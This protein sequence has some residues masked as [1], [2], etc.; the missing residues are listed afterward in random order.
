MTGA[1]LGGT[2]ARSTYEAVL[3][4]Q[5]G[6]CKSGDAVMYSQAI[7]EVNEFFATLH[8]SCRG[9]PDYQV[10]EHIRVDGNHGKHPEPRSCSCTTTLR[11]TTGNLAPKPRW[12]TMLL[13]GSD[14]RPDPIGDPLDLD[15]NT[16]A[17]A[18]SARRAAHHLHA[19]EH[20][21]CGRGATEDVRRL[22]LLEHRREPRRLGLRPRGPSPVANS[23][24]EC[25]RQRAA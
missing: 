13:C 23:R 15:G 21:F 19:P 5:G 18:R 2:A 22:A 20:R 4:A 10:V 1:A 14:P 7:C 17:H 12:R 6:V 24:A 25:F 3:V 9:A 11:L 16:P 8:R